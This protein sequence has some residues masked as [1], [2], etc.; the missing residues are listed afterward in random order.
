MKKVGL[1]TVVALLVLALGS[2]SWAYTINGSPN[3]AIGTLYESYGIDVINFTPG[4]NSGSIAFSLFTDFP[5]GGETVNGSPAWS[6]T[7]ADVFITETWYGTQ[8][9][10]AVPLV[11]HGA[12]SA[13]TMYAVGTSK[14][15]DDFDPSGGSGYIYNH[16]FPVEIATIGS[17]YGYTA[18]GGG[19]VTW[20]PLSGNP[21][22]RVDVTL[23]I[24][25][26]D[27]NGSFAFSWGTATCANDIVE[28][29]VPSTSTSTSVPE[30]NVL[31]LLGM[32]FLGLT[33]VSRRK[34]KQEASFLESGPVAVR[35]MRFPGSRIQR[36]AS[37]KKN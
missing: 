34:Q 36:C 18:V 20:N 25:E 21:D 8:Y 12:F 11:T 35:E 24:Y 32:G 29:S 22:Y 2:V 33:Y 13:G 6:T 19:P 4:V 10:W 27:P 23:G 3:D 31:S 30:P 26:D 28:G 14:V 15:S 17:N 5:Q 7:P 9:E 16:N 37:P 1:L